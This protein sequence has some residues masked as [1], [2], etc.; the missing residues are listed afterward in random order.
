MF[1]PIGLTRAFTR[2]EDLA[3]YRFSV[4]HRGAPGNVTVSRPLSRS[5]SV[6]AGGVSMSLNDVLTYGKFHLGDGTGKDGK[7]VL[8]KA[9]L[10][11]MRT[12]KVR[13]KG[14]DE[15]MGLGW[16]LRKVNGVMTA[17]HGGTLGHCL[18]LELVPER[19]LVMAILTNHSDGWRLIQDVERASL[20]IL[21]NMPLD[22]SQSIGHRGVN[23]TLP[24]VK[25]LEKQPD[26]AE[27][28]GVYRR[29]P[30][31]MNTVAVRDGQLVVDNNTIGFFAPDRAVM[32]SGNGRGNPLE[33]IRDDS[34]VVRWIRVVGRIARKE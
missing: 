10:E 25:L 11:L 30:V 27:Y 17:A 14:T 16:H 28:I 19:N 34:G 4:A 20:R 26:P 2:I 5:V 12:P 1:E 32:T 33:F 18:L 8:S 15:D 23:E 7:P 3:T 9:T 21:E 22:P 24:D 6:A 29:P 31:G 13:K